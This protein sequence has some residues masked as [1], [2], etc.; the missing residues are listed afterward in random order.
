MSNVFLLAIVFHKID[1]PD[2][3]D[4]SETAGRMFLVAAESR[5]RNLIADS[6][7]GSFGDDGDGLGQPRRNLGDVDLPVID[8]CHR[9]PRGRG[10]G[11]EL[12]RRQR[13]WVPVMFADLEKL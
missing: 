5:D 1:R 9:R 8:L 7:L 11:Q 4:N 12:T 3:P 6:N 10:R 2:K 13:G